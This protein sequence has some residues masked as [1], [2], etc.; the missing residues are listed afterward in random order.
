MLATVAIDLFYSHTLSE[1]AKI[2]APVRSS[3]QQSAVT[4]IRCSE[5][6]LT[7]PPPPN[8]DSTTADGARFSC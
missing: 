3:A 8:Q 1:K 4:L 2:Q 6:A 7:L 5:K